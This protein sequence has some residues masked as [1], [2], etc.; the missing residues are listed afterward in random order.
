MLIVNYNNIGQFNPNGMTKAQLKAALSL[1]NHYKAVA[2]FRAD[3]DKFYE[4]DSMIEVVNRY[5]R[6]NRIS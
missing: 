3:E 1:L 4:V 6:K 2:F 5:M